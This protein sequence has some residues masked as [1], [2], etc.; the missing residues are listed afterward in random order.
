MI[1]KTKVKV[2]SERSFIRDLNHPHIDRGSLDVRKL[3]GILECLHE[4]VVMVINSAGGGLIKQ[5]YTGLYYKNAY[6]EWQ[7]Y[8]AKPKIP[9]ILGNLEIL[10]GRI[11][12]GPKRG[13]VQGK[14]DICSPYINSIS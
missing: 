9:D 13:H 11:F 5:S 7:L 10:A 1:A 3:Y 14:E 2:N 8:K 4:Q 6:N 12:L